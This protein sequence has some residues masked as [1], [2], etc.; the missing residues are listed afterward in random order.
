MKRHLAAA[1]L[2]SVALVCGGAVCANAD[3][4]SITQIL[5]SPGDLVNTSVG[6]TAQ[7]AQVV[8]LQFDLLYDPGFLSITQFT[9]GSADVA[10]GKMLAF[11]TLLPG[12]SRVV[13]FG[14]NQNVIG[15]GG[16]ADLQI[17]VS[18]S[19]PVGPYTLLLSNA[20]AV[21]ANAN[22][23]PIT[24]INPSTAVP[25]PATL[26]LLGPALAGLAL[27]RKKFKHIN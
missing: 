22:P 12:D 18:S 1:I 21:D 27:S 17:Q 26:W 2:M 3:E 5:A 15:D 19:A 9:A 8:A 6:Y 14:L 10:A 23:V 4:L 13:I 20:E 25:E 7:G 16:V 11:N 24:V